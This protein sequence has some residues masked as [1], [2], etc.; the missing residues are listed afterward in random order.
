MSN[1]QNSNLLRALNCQPVDRKPVWMMRQAGRYLPEYRQTRSQVNSFTELCKTPELACEVTLQPL[2]RFDLDAAIIFSDILTIPE[3]M[4]QS[5]SL[6][7]GQGPVLE[8][9]ITDERQINE[10]P[11][12][13][14]S[15]LDYVMQAIRLTRDHLDNNTPLIG[16]TGSPWTIAC[17]MVEGQ[18]SKNFAK[19][20]TMMYQRPEL[21][22]QLLQ[23]LAHVIEY[24]IKAQIDAGADAIMMFDSWGGILSPECYQKHS[25]G[26]ISAIIDNVRQQHQAPITL[27][28]KGGGLWL[29][30]QANTGVDALSIDWMTDL[31][32][33]R[34]RLGPNIALQGNLDPAA[35]FSTPENVSE[36]THRICQK[37]NGPGHVF[38]LGH[39]VLPETPI[40]NVHAMIEAAHQYQ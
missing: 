2:R 6:I 34:Q 24:Y 7:S 37:H 14:I 13:D 23:K 18:S 10:L 19:I 20:K 26:P 25:L 21:L 12:I 30:Q 22:D 32:D 9:A 5:L 8:P 40:E 1:R 28:T 27:F 17:Y 35:L 15:E 11:V 4:G 31:A 16:F 33:A 36:L 29:E 39:G 3:A 38:N